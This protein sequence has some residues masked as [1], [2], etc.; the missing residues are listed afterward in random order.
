MRFR[1]RRFSHRFKLTHKIQIAR[2]ISG[3]ITKRSD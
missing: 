1:P 3:E 2:E